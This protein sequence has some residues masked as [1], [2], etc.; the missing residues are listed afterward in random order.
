[1]RQDRNVGF[2]DEGLQHG[3]ELGSIS[4]PFIERLIG[5]T[6]RDYRDQLFFWN[7]GDLQ[8]KLD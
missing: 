1:M 7:A 8:H 5:A 6:R 3:L 2:Q 4:H